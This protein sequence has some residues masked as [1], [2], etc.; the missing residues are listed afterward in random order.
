MRQQGIVRAIADVGLGGNV[1][2][3]GADM[4]DVVQADA[5]EGRRNYRH[6]NP[7]V[8]QAQDFRAPF[9]ALERVSLHGNDPVVLQYGVE[10]LPALCT[11]YPFHG[12]FLQAAWAEKLGSSLAIRAIS[13]WSPLRLSSMCVV[14]MFS[15]PDSGA[16][17]DRGMPLSCRT[18]SM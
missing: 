5:I 17:P 1:L 15:T 12:G 2:P 7:D 3:F 13:H 10:R 11:A 4:R 8:G 16:G 9:V 18:T 14:R 6:L